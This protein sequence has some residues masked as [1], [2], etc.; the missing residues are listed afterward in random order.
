[1]R[2][3]LDTH[4][5]LAIIEQQLER[6]APGIRSLLAD[7]TG[8]FHVSVASLWEI[9]IKWRL[10][11]LRLNPGLKTLPGLLTSMRIE[12]VPINEH[13]TLIAVEPE[14][15]T[16]DPF[17]RLLLAQCQVEDLRLVTIDRALVAHPMAVK[18]KQTS[19]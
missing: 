9:A 12:L 6:F 11:K 14:P 5:L 13:H 3:L 7:P 17:D 1:M 4:I 15:L 10:G 19:L 18:I 2:V 8:E 16:R